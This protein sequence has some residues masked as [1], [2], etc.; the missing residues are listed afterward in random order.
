MPK[1]LRVRVSLHAPDKWGLSSVGRAAALQAVGQR[2]EPVIL[3]Q[4]LKM[5]PEVNIHDC[6]LFVNFQGR[7]MLSGIVEDYPDDHKAYPS[8]LENGHRVYTTRVVKINEDKTVVETERTIYTVK[9]WIPGPL[10]ETSKT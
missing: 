3:H 6:Y 9:N 8:A 7:Q 1:G 2:F 5:K 4:G 10:D